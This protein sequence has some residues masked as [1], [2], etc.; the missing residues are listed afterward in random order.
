MNLY[1]II[2]VF[3]FLLFIILYAFAENKPKN[4]KRRTRNS[5]IK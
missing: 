3:P 5:R 4:G 1:T 2:Y